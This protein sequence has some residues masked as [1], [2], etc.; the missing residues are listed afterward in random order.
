MRRDPD[1]TGALAALPMRELIL[2]RSKTLKARWSFPVTVGFAVRRNPDSWSWMSLRPR[3]RRVWSE[4]RCFGRCDERRAGSAG[5]AAALGSILCP[6]GAS[7]ACDV[8]VSRGFDFPGGADGSVSAEAGPQAA[9]VRGRGAATAGHRSA[10]WRY[11]PPAWRSAECVE[12]YRTE[13]IA[14]ID[15]RLGVGSADAA[16][17]ARAQR[18]RRERELRT[19]GS[20]TP[21]GRGAAV[22]AKRLSNAETLRLA[23]ELVGLPPL[24]AA[25]LARAVKAS[26]RRRPSKAER[27]EVREER[28][29][30]A[31]AVVDAAIKE[32]LR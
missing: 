21:S 8:R 1:R 31:R 18:E 4:T 2:V 6:K 27:A 5:L 24:P 22:K 26:P 13:R 3:P 23:R 10:R 7:L 32:V 17:R 16:L 12:A 29:A 11:R 9:V 30:A 19:S 20:S 25:A 14:Q 15:R 28:Q